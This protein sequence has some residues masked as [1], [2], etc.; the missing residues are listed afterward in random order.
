MADSKSQKLAGKTKT[1]YAYV[2]KI[3]NSNQLPL[4]AVFPPKRV[5]YSNVTFTD[6]IL[7]CEAYPSRSN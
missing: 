7:K 6:V 4:L 3:T 5:F 1:K 2:N